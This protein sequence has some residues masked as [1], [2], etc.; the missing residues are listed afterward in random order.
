MQKIMKSRIVKTIGLGLFL[1][2][3]VASASTLNCAAPIVDVASNGAGGL[4]PSSGNNCSLA[5]APGILFSNFTVAPTGFTSATV[6]IQT[7]SAATG[8]QVNL[9]FQIAYAGGQASSAIGDILLEYRVDGGIQGVD[10]SLQATQITQGGFMQITEIVCDQAFI[11]NACQGNTL[12]NYAVTSSGN[13]V[14]DFR[15]FATTGTVFIK[16]DILFAGAT[17]TEFTNSQAIPEPATMSMMGLGLLGLGLV[18]RKF[19][20]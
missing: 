10:I 5:G 12:A 19:R 14:H 3:S 15:N 2:A 13:F 6:G 18:G 20:K 8:G 9:D 17:A 11:S 1:V 4:G 7:T 16:K